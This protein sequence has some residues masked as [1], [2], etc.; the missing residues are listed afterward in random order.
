MDGFLSSNILSTIVNR[1]SSC[2]SLH[3]QSLEFGTNLKALEEMVND[4][5]VTLENVE[6]SVKVV[7]NG[8]VEN[9]KIIQK[10]MER[11]D[12]E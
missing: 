11:F 5:E 3:T 12:Q 7:E 6:E 4:V 8:L 2:A 9:M 1:L 10:N